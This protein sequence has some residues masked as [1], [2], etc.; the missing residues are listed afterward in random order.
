[1][2]IFLH[3]IT[4]LAYWLTASEPPI[5]SDRFNARVFFDCRPLQKSVAYVADRF[6]FLPQPLQVAA[7]DKVRRMP[8]GVTSH[9]L[10]KRPQGK[11]FCRIE[12][13]VYAS[14]PELCFIQIAQVLPFHELVRA[15]N[16]LC[17]TFWLDPAADGR[18]RSRKPITTKRRL[19]ACL[20]AN[21]GM[22]GIK[23]ARAALHWV[24][25][26]AASPPEAFLAMVLG[27]PFRYG[28][29]QM[30]DLRINKKLPP[31]KKVRAISGRRYLVPDILIPSAG[32]AVEYDST[33]EHAD[34]TQLARDAQKRLALEAEGYKAV[35]VTARQLASR[36]DMRNVAGQIY[37]RAGMRLRP[38][39]GSFERQQALLFSMGWSIDGYVQWADAT[40]GQPCA[41]IARAHWPNAVVQAFAKEGRQ[42]GR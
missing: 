38:Q 8:E 24:V 5:D 29:F 3:G 37:R 28:G 31:S 6:P 36:E 33:A 41:S 1:M 12:S 25:E 20:R 18:L 11:V 27:L 10:V 15:G 19:E 32:V 35:T 17:G 22:L 2:R 21:P 23:N 14:S 13:G 30:T 4:A 42:D 39:S 34:A 7:P 16:A 9:F 26:G 40:K